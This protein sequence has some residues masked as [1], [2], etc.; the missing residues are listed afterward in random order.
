MLPKEYQLQSFPAR[1]PDGTPDERTNDFVRAVVRGFHE[2]DSSGPAS[3]R[4]VADAAADGLQITLV[5]RQQPGPDP[6]LRKLPRGTFASFPGNINMGVGSMLP[7]AMISGVTVRPTDRRR[8][9]LTA[10]MEHG[11]KQ[12]AQAGAPV[13]LLIASEGEIYGRYGFQPVFTPGTLRVDNPREL[14]WLPTAQQRLEEPGTVEEVT[15]DWLLPHMAK[16][17]DQFHRRYRL[18]ISRQKSFDSF[19]Y[20]DPQGTTT[21]PTFRAAVHLDRR[22]RLD[23]YITFRVKKSGGRSVALIREIISADSAAELALWRYACGLDLIDRLE[24]AQQPPEGILPLAVTNPRS[25]QVV[26]TEDHLW[27]R[28]LNP[29]AALTARVYSPAARQAQM[30]IRFQVEDPLGWAAGTFEVQLDDTGATV[31]K[32]DTQ[33]SNLTFTAGALASL[34]FGSH[35]ASML[36]AAGQIKGATEDV[37]DYLDAFFAPV[38]PARCAGDF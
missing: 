13:A 3:A 8:G 30:G 4:A 21:C 19:T 16:V 27:G 10:M 24:A 28:V 5:E 1:L 14:S 18:S 7:A 22:G 38:G 12:A 11:L 35:S 20:L 31:T 37:A 2:T 25:I 6:D 26:G 36:A 29:V 15:L 17:Y 34:T 9:L 32:V 33:L 23:G